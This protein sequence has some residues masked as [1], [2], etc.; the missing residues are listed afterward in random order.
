MNNSETQK[1]MARETFSGNSFFT[2]LHK[3]ANSEA[4]RGRLQCS[5]GSIE[6]PVFMPVG[7]L[8]SVKAV[9]PHQL[10]DLGAQIILG[11]TYHLYLRPGADKIAAAGGLQK[12]TSWKRPML[13]DSGGFQVWSLKDIRTIS[14]AGVKF[15]SHLDGSSHFFSPE[16]VME[17]QRKLGA[18]IIMA[19]DECTNYPSTFL[20]AEK[21][22]RLT[23]GWTERAVQWLAKN[24]PIHQY[25]QFFFG[26]AQG[27]MHPEL[28]QRAIEHLVGLD[29]P[30][31]AIG[32]LSVG[33]PAEEMY[34]MAKLCTS[35]LPQD[36]PRYV[37]GVGTPTN[38]LEM[39]GLGVD[40]FDCVM[41]TRN[42]RNGMLFS[43]SGPIHYKSAR[44][45]D[46]HGVAPDSDCDCYTCQNF[47]IAYLRHLFK[48]GEI[49]ALTLA[50]LHNLHFY[51]ALMTEARKQ[52]EA[53]NFE[54]W[55]RA[56]IEKWNLISKETQE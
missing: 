56:L 3:S 9:N 30:G 13:T 51:C 8:G 44:Y 55:S 29:L 37:M 24:P 31:Y 4:R 36:K 33:E 2:L 17:I 27:G 16:S 23:Q 45:A 47:S 42:A 6:T 1:T 39:I 25:P 15:K 12:F 18:D 22:L 35:G 46:S 32:G 40:M 5:H 38:L 21:S 26:I 54:S 53:G 41:P 50:S 14:E 43:W 20:E 10:V 7:T 11:N 19:F 49:L 48:S 52:I 34:S 28:R